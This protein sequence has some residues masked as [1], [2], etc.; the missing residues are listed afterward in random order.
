MRPTFQYLILRKSG[1]GV[2]IVVDASLYV[3]FAEKL[4][5]PLVTLDTKLRQA[6]SPVYIIIVPPILGR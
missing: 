3:A 6:S 2:S 4:D 5:C 1:L